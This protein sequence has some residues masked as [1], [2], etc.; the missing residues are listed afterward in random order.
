M[1][2]FLDSVIGRPIKRLYLDPLQAEFG[3]LN[4][5]Q[6]QSVF[7]QALAGWFQTVLL[8]IMILQSV[9]AGVLRLLP[10][11]VRDAIAFLHR[12]EW[13]VYLAIVLIM[14]QIQAGWHEKIV[15]TNHFYLL[16]WPFGK[17]RILLGPSARLAQIAY[18]LII[19]LLIAAIIWV[20]ARGFLVAPTPR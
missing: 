13:G 15:L 12:I 5:E 14:L 20:R 4:A 9:F 17:R 18:M 6:R 11:D 3:A 1:Q 2:G 19:L 7:R 8:I 16:A 10:P